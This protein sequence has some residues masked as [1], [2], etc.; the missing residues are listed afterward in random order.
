MAEIND[1][2]P[3][4]FGGGATVL[5]DDKCRKIAEAAL[6]NPHLQ[7]QGR[8]R[9]ESHVEYRVIVKEKGNV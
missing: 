8:I 2:W 3:A 1:W 7:V 4:A 6:N 5:T 9:G